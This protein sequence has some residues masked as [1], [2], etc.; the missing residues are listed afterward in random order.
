MVSQRLSRKQPGN[1]S[2]AA[3]FPSKNIA[4][5]NT[6]SPL[7]PRRNLWPSEKNS[8][9][10]SAPPT[11]SVPPSQQ[12]E[13]TTES[14]AERTTNAGS[15]P[16]AG[17]GCIHPDTGGSPV[18][19]TGTP[20]SIAGAACRRSDPGGTGIR[21]LRK[22]SVK[23]MPCST[24][25]EPGT[26][27][28]TPLP[29]SPVTRTLITSTRSQQKLWTSHAEPSPAPAA[30]SQ[31]AIRSRSSHGWIADTTRPVPRPN[32]SSRP[33]PRTDSPSAELHRFAC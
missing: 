26:W 13:S 29:P 15:Q 16:L 19:T 18:T 27:K 28:S 7:K 4:S 25:T 9:P 22:S 30:S 12:P 17:T 24:R 20:D 14:N 10:L 11:T 31:P 32:C 2:A 3:A 1:P 33:E 5:P 6:K 21:I 8:P 23:V